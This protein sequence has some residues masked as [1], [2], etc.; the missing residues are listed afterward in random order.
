[1]SINRI[2]NN[3]EWKTVSSA[4]GSTPSAGFEIIYPKTDGNWYHI[5]ASG[6]EK[7]IS[8]SYN[9]GNGFTYSTSASSSIYNYDVSLPID[10]YGITLSNGLLR[11]GFI[12]ASS[13]SQNGTATASYV[14]S[15]DSNGIP[16]WVP[17]TSISGS[18]NYVP[19]FNNVASLTN[20]N[21][22][23]DDTTIIIGGTLS[24]IVGGFQPKLYVSGNVDISNRL[25]FTSSN[26]IYL[27]GDNSSNKL[28]LNSSG[29]IINSSGYTIYDSIF[30]GVNGSTLN[31][32]NNAFRITTTGSSNATSSIIIPT[33]TTIGI[34]TASPTHLLHIFSTQPALRLVD[35]SQG[36]GKILIS[37]ASGVAS[38]YM[39][40]GIGVSITGYTFSVQVQNNSG[41]T[42]TTGG[43]SIILQN[44]SGL[45]LSSTGISINPNSIGAGL[46]FTGGTLSVTSIASNVSAGN[47]L[48]SSG[49][50]FSVLLSINSGLT[51]SSTGISINPNSIGA[52][53]TFTGGTLSVTSVSA[54]ITGNTNSIP[55]FS[56]SSTL[57]SSVITQ[58]SN[59][60]LIGT[61]SNIGTKLYIVGS[62]SSTADGIINNLRIGRA[63]LS[64]NIV[65]GNSTLN[66]SSAGSYNIGIGDN[67]LTSTNN[68]SNNISIGY[69]SSVD[70][71]S[72]SDNIS[73][74]NNSL[75]NSNTSN[76][77]AIGS[78]AS[79]NSGGNSVAMGI[80]S[81]RGGFGNVSIGH[82]SGASAIGGYN[83]FLGYQSGLSYVGS[84]S[85]FIGGYDT[86]LNTN[87][88]IFISD[89]QG[90]LRVYVPSTGN[91]LIG[92]M[93]DVGSKLYISGSVSIV[94]S[95]AGVLRLVDTTQGLGKILVSDQNG[96]ANW[97]MPNGVG[98]TISGYTFSILLNN[99]SGLTVSISGLSTNIGTGLT[100]SNNNIIINS[101]I[102]G[103]GLTYSNGTINSLINTG[104]GLTSSGNTFSVNL[105]TSSGLTLSSLGLGISLDTSSGL[106]I[107]SNG[108]LI[109]SSIAGYGLTYSSGSMSFTTN[110][111][112]SQGYIPYFITTTALT[113]SVIYQTSSNILIGTTSNNGAILQV[114][115][116]MSIISATGNAFRLVD[117]TQGVG[118]VLES[119][120]NGFASWQSY[121]YSGTQSFV[122]NLASVVSHNLNTMFYII[123]LF[124]YTTGEEI[125]GGYTNRGLTQATITLT[126]DVSNCGLIIM[127]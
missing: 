18:I 8:I 56:A 43:L 28:T 59:N 108:I 102:A 30:N 104:N 54:N 31:L 23:D 51:V 101:N 110:I 52:G 45:T 86:S 81:G 79:Y 5:G 116:S 2:Y 74:G 9:L 34:G 87:N 69:N 68:T 80:L 29:F 14:L 98:I 38:W 119:D 72:A 115:G 123:Q 27:S 55:Y 41:L 120:V 95:A 75:N 113:S 6:N 60:I 92:T 65:I 26:N 122:A 49:N 16:V 105:R 50:T 24:S 100:I 94:S 47:G 124:D 125:L 22:Y 127:G 67:S 90:N 25:Y 58:I 61:T 76:N 57:T 109:N 44:N 42:A 93:S 118:K 85:V 84:Y 91:V 73:I 40:S 11:I 82:R 114:A 78:S 17:N 20:S 121:K 3:Q 21:I 112:S 96:V 71:I 36:L 88:N 35:S 106:S 53:L 66:N 62:F 19:K 32:L 103:S 64:T 83:V 77:I 7:I 37:D 15:V 97:Y 117:G 4:T 111:N 89:G 12:T 33:I 1:M 99:N 46:T 107:S 126:Q 63:N 10:N 13:L 39:P 48:T 70:N